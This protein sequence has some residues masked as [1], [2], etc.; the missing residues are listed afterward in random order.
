MNSELDEKI[1]RARQNIAR[2]VKIEAIQAQL[3][4]EKSALG[5][6]QRS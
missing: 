5:K 4:T 6:S 3:H 1:L 2:L